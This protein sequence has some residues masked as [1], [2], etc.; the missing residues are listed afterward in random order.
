MC[1]FSKFF[2]VYLASLL[3][4][5]GGSMPAA[6]QNLDVTFRYVPA[7]SGS[8]VI[9][10][11]LPGE[12]NNWGPNNNGVIA[13]NAP[14]LM[15]FQD[16]IGQW[17]YTIPLDIGTTYQYK[18][19]LH[20]N[21]AGSSWQWIT[22]PLNSRVNTSDNNNSVLM[23]RDPMVFQPA[24]EPLSNDLV[25][26]VSASLLSLVPVTSIRFW[27][28]GVER[29]GLPFY[30]ASNGVFRYE[31]DRPVKKGA[32]F[33]IVFTD[34][35]G[36]S[37]SLEVGEIQSP[38]TWQASDFETV[39]SSVRLSATITR[40]D[41]TIDSTLTAAAITGMDGLM[42]AV[43]VVN[44]QVEVTQELV[45]G[46][47]A[48]VLE[49]DVDGQSFTSDTLRV[50]R[51]VHPLD[52][53]LVDP[54]VTGSEF[55]FEI[56]AMPAENA[57][58]ELDV[59]WDFD[60]VLST[61]EVT[62]LSIGD[63]RVSGVVP[64]A[65]EYY[66]DLR[67]STEEGAVDRQRVAMI[68]DD[69]G[70][71]RSMRYEETPEWVDRAV[72][73]EIFPLSFG[74]RANGSVAAPGD[75][76]KEITDELDYI[77]GMG[78]NTIW[79]MP[80]MHNLTM[81]PLSGGYNIIDFYNVDPVLGTN[82][83]FKELV[84]RAHDLG[85][86]IVMDITPNHASPAHPW[87]DA[88]RENGAM[89]P[90]GSFIQ[91][92][93][94]GHNRGLDNRGPNLNEIWQVG[95]EGNL[96]RKYDGF[97]DLA[98]LNWDDDD[99]QA[100]FLKILTHWIHEFDIDGWR[101]DVYWGP[102]RRYGPERF[103]EPVREMMKRIKPD[104]W[105]LGEIAGTGVSTEVYY[106]D[107]DNGQAVVGGIDAGYDWVFYFDAIRGSYADIENY[108]AKIRNNNFWPGPNA[109]YFRFLENH[110][111]ERIAKVYSANP[112][113]IRPLTGML[114]T[115]PGI[116]MI[117]QGQEVNF[118]D[119]AGDGR[120][121]SVRW[122]TARNQ[123]FARFHQRLAHARSRFPA[124][125]TQDFVTLHTS[126]GVYAYSRPFLDEN[127][128]V[129]INFASVERQ[130]TLDPTSHVELSTDGPVAYTDVFTDTTYVDAELDGFTMT[131]PAYETVIVVANQDGVVKFEIPDLPTFPFESINTQIEDASIGSRLETALHANYPNPFRA[132][133]SI[134]F[135]LKKRARVTLE[136]YDLLGRKVKSQIDNEIRGAGRHVEIFD[137][138]GLP[139]GMYVVRLKA[140]DKSYTRLITVV[141]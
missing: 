14:S 135:D 107:N 118:G 70:T 51:L 40:Q 99:L 12:F 79:F 71:V 124:F 130:V 140:E 15:T 109:R 139:G 81:T 23:V 48:F 103:G 3:A 5:V 63:G 35:A 58:G 116:P 1:L 112:E 126:L 72:V 54:E 53:F 68:V 141:K 111:E 33:K 76:L 98:N 20:F 59:V 38:I 56:R 120:R 131:V 9:R 17:L 91:T 47:N 32:Q 132:S 115:A 49:A 41:G 62:S 101:F 90:P 46:P 7:E 122:N 102:W 89:S 64:E 96:Y 19:H 13:A 42:E 110:D 137:V 80:V 93:P 4:T 24:R 94:S 136:L 85:I 29:D 128:I 114:L 57:P 100:E 27:V 21:E 18:V 138:E 127:V 74:P 82:E 129:A 75:K 43:D 30:D 31:L 78:F 28:N 73:Y 26:A 95:G 60:D 66:F 108:D 117:Y 84:Q 61:S 8:P 69:A 45:L 34:A 50:S 44:G 25:G 22:D 67:A 88:L 39:R 77:A 37:D 121:V 52:A 119:V 6:G 105:I 65:G 87:V 16:S 97:G 86:R 11:F 83:D 104:S 10:A 2:V 55:N 125:G 134:P 123:E 36:R 133:T 106:T 113:R 92:I